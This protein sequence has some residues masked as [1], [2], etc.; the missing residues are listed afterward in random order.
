M[1]T[2]P[3]FIDFL[4]IT[5]AEERRIVKVLNDVAVVAG[6]GVRGSSPKNV[7]RTVLQR[8]GVRARKALRT[9]TPVGRRPIH[10]VGRRPL[11]QT[12]RGGVGNPGRNGNTIYR[13]G[14]DRQFFPPKDKQSSGRSGR[15]QQTLAVEHGTEKMSARN[16]VSAALTDAVGPG[17]RDFRQQFIREFDI[18]IGQLFAKANA[19]AKSGVRRA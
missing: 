16:P 17:G 1:P 8:V 15:F 14:Y 19:K 4:G 3:K 6:A 11:K 2:G 13:A 18:R 12:V 10:P 5:K 7:V 9:R